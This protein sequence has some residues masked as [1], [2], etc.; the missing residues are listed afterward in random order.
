MSITASA[1]GKAILFGE[2]S[3]VY[4]YPALS[5]PV[6]SLRARCT[7][8]PCDG[9][10]RLIAENLGRRYLYRVASP[11][12]ALA[13]AVRGVLE[14]LNE[15]E[16]SLRLV[17]ESDLPIGGGLGSG[18]AV[19][20]AVI[21]CVAA[22]LGHPMTV[23]RLNALV[24]EVEKLHHGTPSGVD[25]TTVVYEQPVYFVKG[26]PPQP[27]PVGAPFDLL[28]ADTGESASTR[29]VV[30]DV[31]ALYDAKREEITAIFE[32]IGA[33]V[34]QARD[35]IAVGDAGALGPLMDEN[36]ALLC[37][38]TVSSEKLDAM[39][40]A[41]RR[42]GALGA[43]LSGAGRGGNLIALVGE[44]GDHEAIEAALNGAGAVQIWRVRV[45]EG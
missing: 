1:P 25:N 21:R 31:R 34:E 10:M 4:G 7:A 39:A 8:D 20:A 22:A 42:A 32:S 30:A 41:A 24:Y 16:P 36:H 28:I 12:D 14:E 43:K 9:P 33:V 5:V 26:R 3:V 6:S 38:L 18:A 17:V 37:R 11:E 15:P 45:G 2:H 44:G 40:R 19:S 13:Y 27:F 29:K 23:E 35:V